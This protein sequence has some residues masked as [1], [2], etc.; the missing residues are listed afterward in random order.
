MAK[1]VLTLGSI[2]FK[3]KDKFNQT[4]RS[5][6][7]RSI[8]HSVSMA[9]I[10]ANPVVYCRKYNLYHLFDFTKAQKEFI[11]G[12]EVKDLHRLIKEANAEK[13]KPSESN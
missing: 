2:P 8:G 3:V 5:V 9:T 4:N 7:I 6:F 12:L 1:K 11:E 13:A 10:V